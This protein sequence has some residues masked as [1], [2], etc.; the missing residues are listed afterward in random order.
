MSLYK[1]KYRIESTRLRNWD[2]TNAAAYF[3]T[4]CTKHRICFFGNIQNGEM[5]LND[6]GIIVQNE[7]LKTPAIRP[8]MNLLLDAFIVMPNH[9]HAIICIGDNEYNRERGNGRGC[10][11][12]AAS[13]YISP[14]RLWCWLIYF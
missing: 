9:F 7:W 2:Y 1:N 10:L 3:V 13:F 8:D 5:L 14:Y 6:I 12:R 4:I 11:K